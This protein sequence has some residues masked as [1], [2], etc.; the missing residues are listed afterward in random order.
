MSKTRSTPE[1]PP[2]I[3]PV[4]NVSSVFSA[5]RD[6]RRYAKF[7]LGDSGL[8][9]EEADV[10]VTLYGLTE[11]KW[12]DCPVG[13]DGFVTSADVKDLLTHDASL[14]AKRIKK[15]AGPG[16]RLV[17]VRRVTKK[18]APA[19][20]GN[21]QQIRITDTGIAAA[22]PIWE[23]FRKLAA[24][25]FATE[26]LKSFSQSDLEV[27]ARINDAMSQAIRDWRNPAKRL[28]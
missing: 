10:L 6:L 4:Y 20:H 11:L 17:E 5:Q 15:L 13:D 8:S 14:Y 18:T 3:D 23:S 21:T 9:V 25:L 12:T 24:K 19:L 16:F 2:G 22:K 26:P 1:P 28:L 7:T 27:H